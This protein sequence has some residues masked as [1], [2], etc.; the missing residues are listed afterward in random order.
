[1]AH[2]GLHKLHLSKLHLLKVGVVAAVWSLYVN[3]KMVKLTNINK[4]DEEFCCL[5]SKNVGVVAG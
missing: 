4:N 1:M 3:L 2:E 5:L